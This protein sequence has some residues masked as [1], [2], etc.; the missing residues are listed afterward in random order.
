MFESKEWVWLSV[1]LWHAVTVL[2]CSKLHLLFLLEQVQL[3]EVLAGSSTP[4]QIHPKSKSKPVNSGNQQQWGSDLIIQ[5]QWL[6]NWM[7]M[8]HCK[9]S[10]S[11]GLKICTMADHG[12]WHD[13][14]Q[15]RIMMFSSRDLSFSTP[16][17]T[18][19]NLRTRCNTL[20]FLLEITN[21]DL[22]YLIP[23]SINGG[24][25]DQ[26]CRTGRRD[27]QDAY[28]RPHALLLVC[29]AKKLVSL[30]RFQPLKLKCTSKY[31]T[32]TTWHQTCSFWGPTYLW[33]TNYH[34]PDNSKI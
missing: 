6:V 22:T 17:V 13:E 15:L 32:K 19:P 18:L 11:L 14:F 26:H 23:T 12:F 31:T 1:W 25:A 10:K 2:G 30:Q 7:W 21:Q 27:H 4:E 16:R 5:K 28:Y 9:P 33:G 29:F 20:P 24:P 34:E 3:S 8:Y